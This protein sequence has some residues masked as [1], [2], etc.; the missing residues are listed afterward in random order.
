VNGDFAIRHSLTAPSALFCLSQLI[1]IAIT[2]A[3]FEAIAATLAKLPKV[4][5]G[6][7]GTRSK[8]PPAKPGALR[9]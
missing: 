3:A 5:V 6:L 8:Y 1:R 2:A 9:F 7:G 4:I